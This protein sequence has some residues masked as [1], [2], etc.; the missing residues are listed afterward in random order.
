MADIATPSAAAM[1]TMDAGID[2]TGEVRKARPEKPDE[3]AYKLRLAEAEKAFVA[4][5]QHLVRGIWS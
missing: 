2:P 1:A 5:Q 4:A 3:G